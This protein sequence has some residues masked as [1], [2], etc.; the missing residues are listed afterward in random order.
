MPGVTASVSSV[1][2]ILLVLVVI[3][4]VHV[5]VLGRDR[6]RL[7]QEVDALNA[8]YDE[9]TSVTNDL[10]NSHARLEAQVSYLPDC[11]GELER[12][13]SELDQAEAQADAER[14]ARA[15]VELDQ[16]KCQQRLIDLQ[17]R[18]GLLRGEVEDLREENQRLLVHLARV[19]DEK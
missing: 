9:L 11:L 6:R 16:A 15:E 10:F 17:T 14:A 1:A 8:R 13:R 7:Q 2:I 19:M 4:A 3:L 12:V 18:N 5:L